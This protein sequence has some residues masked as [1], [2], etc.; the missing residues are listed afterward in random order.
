MKKILNDFIVLLELYSSVKDRT[1]WGQ[2][3]PK[4]DEI[5]Y[6]LINYQRCLSKT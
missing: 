4:G 2:D 1:L 3:D 6:P 5:F